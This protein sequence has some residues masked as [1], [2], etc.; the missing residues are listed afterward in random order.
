MPAGIKMNL[1][2]L[3]RDGRVMNHGC[4]D[5]EIGRAHLERLKNLLPEGQIRIG[6]DNGWSSTVL[7]RDG[8]PFRIEDIVKI[9]RP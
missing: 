3:F 7:K 2:T 4:G 8:S 9:W 5:S 6:S 1:L